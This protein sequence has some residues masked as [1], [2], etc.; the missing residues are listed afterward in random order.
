MHVVVSGAG[1][2]SSAPAGINCG[3]T[4]STGFNFGTPV[5]LNAVP[6]A[7]RAFGGWSGACSGAGNHVHG[8]DVG[9]ANGRRRICRRHAM[10]A[11]GHRRRGWHRHHL[12][13]GDRIAARRVSPGLPPARK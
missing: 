3:S 12:A 8:H 11:G 4:C 10:H 9:R 5:T 13:G 1:T 6:A 2:V 7:G